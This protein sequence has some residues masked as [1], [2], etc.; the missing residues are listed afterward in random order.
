MSLNLPSLIRGDV[1]RVSH[2]FRY[3][4]FPV[5]RKESVAE[6]SFWV[7]LLAL[8]IVDDLC[9]DNESKYKVVARALVHDIDESMTGDFIRSVKHSDPELLGRL[10]AISGTVVAGLDT[11]CGTGFLDHWD[12]AKED[13]L[14]G[15]VVRV[16]DFAVVLSYLIEEQSMGNGLLGPL[17]ADL[18]GNLLRL[19]GQVHPLL[20]PYV[21]EVYG[22][23]RDYHSG[24]HGGVRVGQRAKG[25]EE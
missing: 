11:E 19:E 8:A 16:V 9:L 3:S 24:W 5:L 25:E 6:H 7:A 17:F 21:A 22:V 23:A 13:G 10:D 1:R 12:N 15:D 4:S 20:R 14:L 2:V 18:T